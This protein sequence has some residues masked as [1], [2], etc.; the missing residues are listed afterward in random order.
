MS[1]AGDPLALSEDEKKN[2]KFEEA[3]ISEV[4]AIQSYQYLRDICSW[5]LLNVDSPL[6]LGGHGVVVQIDQSLFRHRPKV[7]IYIA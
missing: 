3:K 4:T 7:N 5:R 1:I 2:R 6:L